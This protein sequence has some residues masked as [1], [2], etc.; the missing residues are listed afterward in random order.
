MKTFTIKYFSKSAKIVNVVINAQRGCPT[1]SEW[2][3]R[4]DGPKRRGGSSSPCPWYRN[5]RKLFEATERDTSEVFSSEIV[6]EQGS[7][8]RTMGVPWAMAAYGRMHRQG[9]RT[10]PPATVV[11]ERRI[12]Q[13]SLPPDYVFDFPPPHPPPP[14]ESFSLGQSAGTMRMRMIQSGAGGAWHAR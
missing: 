4:V 9:E 2:F 13:M 6:C 1:P 10:N 8:N 5:I 14:T 3:R 11:G 12:P 7:A